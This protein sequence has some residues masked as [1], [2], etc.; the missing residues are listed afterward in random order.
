MNQRVKGAVM[1]SLAIFLLLT[2]FMMTGCGGSSDLIGRW[3]G[4]GIVEFSS[5]G[6]GTFS[7]WGVSESFT[8]ESESGTIIIRWEHGRVDNGSYEIVSGDS[9]IL[10]RD[11]VLSCPGRGQEWKISQKEVICVWREHVFVCQ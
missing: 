5:D 6:S 4:H 9:L 2:A 7:T 10:S 1:K 11:L 8:W 3:G